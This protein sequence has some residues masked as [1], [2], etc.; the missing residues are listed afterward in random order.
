MIC[1]SPSAF[2]YSGEAQTEDN[3]N[4]DVSTEDKN[5]YNYQL[6]AVAITGNGSMITNSYIY[7]ARNNVYVGDG[8]V[9]IENTTLKNGV[10]ANIQ[11]KSTNASTVTLKDITTIQEE[12]V[13]QKI[14]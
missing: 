5:Y 11:I 10:L 8:N 12:V 3:K 7:G 2:L 13:E 1:G 14:N 4:K 9:T 6:S